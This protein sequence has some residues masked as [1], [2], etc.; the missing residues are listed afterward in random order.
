MVSN[1]VQEEA[2]GMTEG[3]GGLVHS[4]RA[5]CGERDDTGPESDCKALLVHRCGGEEPAGL[6]SRGAA[7]EWLS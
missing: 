4:D 3:K 7:N 1:G 6:S 5:H 2:L